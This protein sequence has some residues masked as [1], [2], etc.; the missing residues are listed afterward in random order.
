MLMRH[1]RWV[2]RLEKEFLVGME[3]E[4]KKAE[5]EEAALNLMAKRNSK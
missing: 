1:S 3:R 2:W 4:K 5:E